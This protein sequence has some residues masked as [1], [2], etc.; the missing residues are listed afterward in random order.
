MSGMSAILAYLAA[1]ALPAYL[2]YRF[3]SLGWYW[4]M[5]SILA[6]LAVGLTPMPSA[7]NNPM[8]E[9]MTGVVF[10]FLAA[11]GIGGLV[12]HRPHRERHA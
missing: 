2:V 4:H 12:V 5:L 9:L 1:L 7:L 6:A 11:W 10:V 3:G 8:G